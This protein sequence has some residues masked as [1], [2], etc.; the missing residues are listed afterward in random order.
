MAAAAGAQLVAQE[1][2]QPLAAAQGLMTEQ[3]AEARVAE[4]WLEPRGA[5]SN[6]LFRPVPA[7]HPGLWVLQGGFLLCWKSPEY[8]AAFEGC[9]QL[10]SALPPL[11][12]CPK[13]PR[14]YQGDRTHDHWFREGGKPI[15]LQKGLIRSKAA[16]GHCHVAGADA[17]R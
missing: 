10:R 12:G 15:A 1:L 9:L 3:A 2:P 13:L 7:G 5:G 16:T 17:T 6:G 14:D 8:P 11:P 4:A